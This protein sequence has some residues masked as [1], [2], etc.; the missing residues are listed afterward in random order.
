MSTENR[1]VDE[2]SEFVGDLP[3]APVDDEQG[4]EPNW[5]LPKPIR[6]ADAD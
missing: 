1:K 5:W 3:P 2:P 6:D 4:K